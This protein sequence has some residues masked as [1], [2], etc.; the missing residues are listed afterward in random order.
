VLDVIKLRKLVAE[1][2][3]ECGVVLLQGV[4][5]TLTKTL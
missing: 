5:T 1:P 2:R 4:V 3:Y